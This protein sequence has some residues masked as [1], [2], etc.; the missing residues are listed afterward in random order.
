MAKKL[1]ITCDRCN[2]VVVDVT[3][4]G[5]DDTIDDLEQLLAERDITTINGK[6]ICREC[7]KIFDNLTDE[8]FNR[9]VCAEKDNESVSKPKNMWIPEKVSIK[10]MYEHF[11]KERQ[12]N[13]SM[14]DFGV[15]ISTYAC[16]S[17]LNNVP[18]IERG[19]VLVNERYERAIFDLSDWYNSKFY[20]LDCVGEPIESPKRVHRAHWEMCTSFWVDRVG[21]TNKKVYLHSD[22]TM[23]DC[24][25]CQVFYNDWGYYPM[26]I[27]NWN[28]I[29]PMVIIDHEKQ[30]CYHLQKTAEKENTNMTINDKEGK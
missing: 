12:A 9:S 8:F 16:S 15:V 29:V 3:N 4:I 6:C 26:E 30:I 14:Q 17:V 18:D 24:N 13:K 10:T 27:K 5:N 7:E 23:Y 11:K 28:G 20:Y 22:G 21:Y 25:N 1:I 2:S 19:I